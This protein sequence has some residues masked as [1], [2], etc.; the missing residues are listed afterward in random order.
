MKLENKLKN[1]A[2]K[3]SMKILEVEILGSTGESREQAIRVYRKLLSESADE[4]T[5][6]ARV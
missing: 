5:Y 4:L 6:L 3:K 2:R 1:D